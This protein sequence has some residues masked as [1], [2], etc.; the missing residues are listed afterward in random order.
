MPRPFRPSLAAG[1]AAV[2]CILM[3]GCTPDYSPNIYAGNAAQQANKVNQGVIVGVRAVQISADTTLATATGGAAGGVVGSGFGEGTGSAVGAV[4]GTIAGGV[5][6]NVVGHAAGDTDGFEYIVKKSNGDLLSVT[7]KDARPLGIG[8][9]VLL[10]EGPQARI[11]P[12]YTVPVV[13]EALHPE[14]VKPAAAK[15]EPAPAV[16]A[17]TPASQPAILPAAVTPAS[18]PGIATT[19]IATPL[20]P[21]AQAAATTPAATPA[22]AATTPQTAAANSSP[23]PKPATPPEAQ[24]TAPKPEDTS[25]PA[26]G[27]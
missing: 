3:A 8:A 12:D 18:M 2:L 13:V 10:I 1:T 14:D 11:V 20:A 22:P 26:S 4:A 16:A 5:V 21:P 27:S 23:E 25:K 19:V 9:H 7:Q 15:T 24:P 6:G 17:T